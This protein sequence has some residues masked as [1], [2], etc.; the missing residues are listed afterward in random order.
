ME[1]QSSEQGCSRQF[2]HQCLEADVGAETRD[3]PH[4]ILQKAGSAPSEMPLPIITC[5]V[6][7][8][9]SLQLKLLFMSMV[10]LLQY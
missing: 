6:I 10:P 7:P 5:Q 9:H 4:C 1:V 3:T 8:H 2:D